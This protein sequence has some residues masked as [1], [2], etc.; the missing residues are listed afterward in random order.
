M[1]NNPKLPAKV[2]IYLWFCK[3]L[4]VFDV[5][6][7]R[8]RQKCLEFKNTKSLVLEVRQKTKQRGIVVF[9]NETRIKQTLPVNQLVKQFVV[10][11]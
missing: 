9:C 8:E 2:N 6:K 11:Y 4:F 10:E 1:P 7:E 5:Q 3:L